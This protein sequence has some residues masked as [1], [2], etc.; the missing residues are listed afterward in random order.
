MFCL[1]VVGSDA[2]LDMPTSSRELYFQL[3]MYADDD[4]FINPKK[5]IRMVGAGDDDLKVLLAKR[6]LLPFSS[7]VVVI[8]HWKLNNSIKSDRYKETVYL[9][10]KKT[11]RIKKNRAYSERASLE[12]KC[13]QNGSAGKVRLGKVRLGKTLSANAD[14]AVLLGDQLYE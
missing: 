7:G 2:F 11:L 10:E 12:P 8:K 9:D 6:F 14:G 13:L 3:G 4:G 5:V 1:E